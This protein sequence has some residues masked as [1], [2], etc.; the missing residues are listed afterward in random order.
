MVL[1]LTLQDLE[2]HFMR[3]KCW[4]GIQD[5]T[6]QEYISMLIQLKQSRGQSMRSKTQNHNFMYVDHETAVDL[7]LLG[8]VGM[9]C[10]CC[11]H[12]F[13]SV[14]DLKEREVKCSGKDEL[15]IKLAC[16][17]HFKWKHK[18]LKKWMRIK[19]WNWQLRNLKN[20]VNKSR[21]IHAKQEKYL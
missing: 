11:L 7:A 5:W 12:V 13:D 18:S 2:D 8:Y 15:G 1:V 19:K 3:Y 4:W 21:G 17:K 14:E 16:G 9:R 6:P 10:S 20:P